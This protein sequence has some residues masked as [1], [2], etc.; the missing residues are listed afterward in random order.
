M[1][2][3]LGLSDI[4]GDVGDTAWDNSYFYVKTPDGWKRAALETWNTPEIGTK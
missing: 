1:G 2:K 3:R 4:N